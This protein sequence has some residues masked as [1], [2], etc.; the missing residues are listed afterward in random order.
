LSPAR[1]EPKPAAAD[2][3][4]AALQ[5]AADEERV[6]HLATRLRLER[7]IEALHA[8]IAELEGELT[9][10]AAQLRELEARM[11]ARQR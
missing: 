9:R 3:A 5:A 8:Q 1:K 6:G 4:L 7:E 2:S 10:S 11:Q